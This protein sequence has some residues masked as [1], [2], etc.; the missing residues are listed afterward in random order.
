MIPQT[1]TPVKGKEAAG[2]LKLF[3]ALDDHDDVKQVYANFDIS[4]EEMRQ[5]MGAG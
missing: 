4:E 5:A 3:E 2:M 1:T